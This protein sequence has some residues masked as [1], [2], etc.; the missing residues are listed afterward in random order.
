LK[1]AFHRSRT[2]PFPLPQPAAID[3]V[4]V[5]SEDHGLERFAGTLVFLDAGKLLPEPPPAALALVLAPFQ[6]D[7]GEARPPILVAHLAQEQSFALQ[8][9]ALAVRTALRSRI[10]GGDFHPPRSLLNLCNLVAG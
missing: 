4:Q 7:D 1:V 6:T 5:L 10:A 2:D 3:A 9:R 8:P